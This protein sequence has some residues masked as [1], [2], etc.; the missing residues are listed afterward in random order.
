MKYRSWRPLGLCVCLC[1]FVSVC[2]CERE[3]ERKRECVCVFVCLCVL[4]VCV[5]MCVCVFARTC[6]WACL[7][8]YVCVCAWERVCIVNEGDRCK[9]VNEW[10]VSY[11]ENV[12][13]RVPFP[14]YFFFVNSYNG[15]TH[16]QMHPST[17]T[18]TFNYIQAHTHTRFIYN[19]PKCAYKHIQMY[20]YACSHSI[21]IYIPT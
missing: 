20:A 19:P 5:C 12:Y 4:R 14:V 8:L 18:H 10:R 3:R 13:P 9:W 21:I 1:V 15:D 7:C 11:T 16:T 17:H 2:V 6:V